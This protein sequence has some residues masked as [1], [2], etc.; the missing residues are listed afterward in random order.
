M[1]LSGSL[2]ITTPFTIECWVKPVQKNDFAT[3]FSNKTPGIS[4]PGLM[5]S[6]NEYGTNN[7]KLYLETSNTGTSSTVAITCN[8]WQHVAVTWD[9]SAV[10]MYLNGNALTVTNPAGVSLVN[11]G[12]PSYL[13]DIPSYIGNANYDGTMDEVRIWNY[14]RSQPQLQA[15]MNCQLSASQTGLLAYYRFN[16]GIADG[17]N[18][19]ITGLPDISGNGHTGTLQ[20]FSLNGDVTVSSQ[21]HLHFIRG[22]HSLKIFLSAMVTA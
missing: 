14:A 2:A 1:L 9:G 8:T 13:G 15:A 4:G 5:F 19:G 17:N 20:N 18:A 22:V 7:G 3:L 11:S 21:Q 12:N 10:R 6:I 16:Q